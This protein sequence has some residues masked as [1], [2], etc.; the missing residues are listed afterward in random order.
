MRIITV[1]EHFEHPEVSRQVLQLGGPPSGLPL[2]ELAE[3][4]S[5]FNDDRD[6]ATVLGGHRLAHMDAV[7]V[8]VQVVSHGNGSP[9]TLG[10]PESVDLCRRVNND[11]AQQISE[12]T[13]TGSG[14]SPRFRF[15]TP[16]RRP[17]NCAAVSAT[18]DSSVP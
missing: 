4:G 6:A 16:P 9:S 14:V 15:T 17:R 7:G 13:Q 8:D 12:H 5:I 18:W 11:L 3:F 10:A 2:N 1:E